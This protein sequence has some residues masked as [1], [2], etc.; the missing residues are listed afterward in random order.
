LNFETAE[1]S[2]RLFPPGASGP[3]SAVGQRLLNRH[4]CNHWND[5][6]GLG[7]VKA[8]KLGTEVRQRMAK[9]QAPSRSRLFIF[10]V[11]QY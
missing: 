11:V 10:N 7:V 8:T 1:I 2:N 5:H 6:G 3:R 9:C 4:S